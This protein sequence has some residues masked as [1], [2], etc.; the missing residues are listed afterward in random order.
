MPRPRGGRLLSLILIGLL[1]VA[2]SPAASAAPSATETPA[3]TPTSSPSPSPSPSPASSPSDTPSASAAAVDP[4]LGLK[5]AA[6]YELVALDP[7]L[8]ASFRQQFATSAGAFASLIG[9]GGREVT[10]SGLLAG[11]VFVIA[12]PAGVLT[13]A[14]Y[15][16]M[17]GGIATGSQLTFT[18]TTI[19]GVSF[20]SGR[21]PRPGSVRS[22][23]GTMSSWSWHR[24]PRR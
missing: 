17:L 1:I 24:P 5:I 19:S 20:S 22:G 4:A 8:E 3:A 12:F 21:P 6:P 7:A 23:S 11:Y 2:C 16:A 18:A 15:Q 14:S 10:S 9:I 13:D